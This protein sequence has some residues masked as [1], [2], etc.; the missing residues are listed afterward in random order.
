MNRST[1]LRFLLH[2]ALGWGNHLPPWVLPGP[3]ASHSTHPLCH[4]LTALTV[5]N[6][7]PT[8]PANLLFLIWAISPGPFWIL[9]EKELPEHWIFQRTL[10]SG[11]TAVE[12]SNISSAWKQPVICLED[13]SPPCMLW[14]CS[15]LI[16]QQIF[17]QPAAH[18]MLVQYL[19]LQGESTAQGR[20]NQCSS[21]ERAWAFLAAEVSPY[22]P[23]LKETLL[24]NSPFSLPP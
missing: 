20:Q 1:R 21:K 3:S 23:G 8:S 13:I 16:P 18:R 22:W 7:L 14:G 5:E 17:V 6:F 10:L 24:T 4:G 2:I 12:T 19:F 11:P 9:E 15:L